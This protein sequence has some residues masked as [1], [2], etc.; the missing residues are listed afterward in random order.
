MVK[1][2]GRKTEKKEPRFLLTYQVKNEG[3]MGSGIFSFEL[4][5]CQIYRM[6]KDARV[7]AELP[8]DCSSEEA[9]NFLAEWIDD[10]DLTEVLTDLEIFNLIPSDLEIERIN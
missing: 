6:D 10:L 7:T 5:A 8:D 4:D 1:V 2:T 9:A 3:G